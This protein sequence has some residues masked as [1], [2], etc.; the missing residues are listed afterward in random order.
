MAHAYLEVLA[1][2]ASSLISYIRNLFATFRCKFGP[3]GFR[4]GGTLQPN[5]DDLALSLHGISLPLSL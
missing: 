1:S 4:R 5:K 2:H 3:S